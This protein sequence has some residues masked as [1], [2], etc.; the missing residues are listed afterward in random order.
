MSCPPNGSSQQVQ[1]DQLYTETLRLE[2]NGIVEPIFDP[3][4]GYR[5]ETN[6][7]LTLICDPGTN[8]TFESKYWEL[9]EQGEQARGVPFYIFR[10]RV[11]GTFAGITAIG[12]YVTIVLAVGRLLRTVFGKE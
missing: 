10:E 2:D 3:D 4:H 11:S 9:M 12:F 8:T 6:A 5:Y 1:I 7:T